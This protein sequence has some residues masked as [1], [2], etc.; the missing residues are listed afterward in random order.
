L[1]YVNV[2]KSQS[3]NQ[4]IK[5]YVPVIQIKITIIKKKILFI[6]ATKKWESNTIFSTI[7]QL[8]RG[9][10]LYWWRK[11]EYPENTTDLGLPQVTDKLYH[12]ML[13]QVHLAMNGI[14]THNIGGNGL[15]PC[16]TSRV[17]YLYNKLELTYHLTAFVF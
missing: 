9:V 10:Q 15:E 7:F 4:A 2:F 8:Y 13:Y 12:I 17:F 3:S 16:R 1:I 6:T 14:Q 11:L 5:V